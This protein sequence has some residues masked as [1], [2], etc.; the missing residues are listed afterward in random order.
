MENL[1]NEQVSPNIIEQGKLMGAIDKVLIKKSIARRV[2]DEQPLKGPLGIV[3]GASWD[4][5]ASKLRIAKADI[6]AVSEKIRTE[7]TIESLQDLQGIYGESFYDLLAYHLVDEMAYRLDARFLQMVKAR[8]ANKFNL[9]FGPTYDHNILSVGQSIMV[10][11]TKGLADLPISDGRSAQGWCVVSSDIASIISFTTTLSDAGQ[12][13]DDKMDTSPSYLGSLLGVDYYIDYTHNNNT[14]D[15]VVYGIKGNGISKG[16]T[17]YSHYNRTW[18]DSIDPTSGEN[19]YFLL[20][21][22]G[23]VINPLDEEFY[24]GGAGTS[25]FLGKMSVDVSQLNIFQAAL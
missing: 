8:A 21:R 2:S 10:A 16:S 14:V 19:V 12:H 24:Q 13:E 5:A 23:M 4:A 1:V 20:D 9:V 3:T 18:I 15:N 22:T 6:E 25:S 11:I 17:I 7:F